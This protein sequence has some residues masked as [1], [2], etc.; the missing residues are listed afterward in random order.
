M[1]SVTFSSPHP[2]SFE[3][4]IKKIT[5]GRAGGTHMGKERHIKGFGGET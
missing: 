2:L 4:H 3:D 5:V 1:R